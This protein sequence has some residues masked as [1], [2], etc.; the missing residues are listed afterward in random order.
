MAV[1]GLEMKE[2][3]EKRD[4]HLPSRFTQDQ[5][6]PRFIRIRYKMKEK[7]KKQRDF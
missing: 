1:L 4:F 5:V 2:N 3:E 7:K 6:S